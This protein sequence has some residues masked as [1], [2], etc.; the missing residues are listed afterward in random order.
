MSKSPELANV[1]ADPLAYLHAARCSLEK[2]DPTEAAWAAGVAAGMARVMAEVV[3]VERRADEA[4]LRQDVSM[5][6]GR[7][8]IGSGRMVR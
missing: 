5:E 4:K 2:G 6:A 7:I 1:T 3:P 8:R